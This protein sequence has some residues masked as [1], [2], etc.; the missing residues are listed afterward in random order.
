M[1]IVSFFKKNIINYTQNDNFFTLNGEVIN[2]SDID[3]VDAKSVLN[4]TNSVY[5]KTDMFAT[6]TVM[7]K[8]IKLK[9]DTTDLGY[10]KMFSELIDA[11]Q[12]DKDKIFNTKNI[13]NLQER[14]QRKATFWK[15]FWIVFTPF[16]LNGMG[17]LWFDYS[18]FSDIDFI[19]MPSE[20]A[21]MLLSIWI[22]TSPMHYFVYKSNA[23]KFQRESD[24]L[25][26]TESDK[27]TN[28]KNEILEQ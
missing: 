28:D 18:F 27:M 3:D 10:Y 24:F 7:G 1:A 9:A 26:Q 15:Y 22:L 25:A 21:G 2:F 20:I 16:A 8:E 6:I 12:K 13:E 5:I 17:S 11:I 14:V 23:R 4:Y 19:N